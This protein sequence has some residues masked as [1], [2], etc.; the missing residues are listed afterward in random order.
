MKNMF[1]NCKYSPINPN[2]TANVAY[3]LT[4]LKHVKL[5]L[6]NPDQFLQF[7]DQSI[8]LVRR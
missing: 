6:L 2:L 4:T 7:S 5:F 8:H 1:H 3:Y